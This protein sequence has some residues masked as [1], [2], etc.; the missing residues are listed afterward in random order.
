MNKAKVWFRAFRPFAYSASITPVAVG[1]ALAADVV[2]LDWPLAVLTVLG[3]VLLHTGTNLVN[4]AYDH[5]KGVD[6][7]GAFGGS[8]VI[9]EGLLS[10]D[11]VRRGGLICFGL[12]ALIGLYLV[13]RVGWGIA[14]FGAA[15]LLLGYLYTGGKGAYKYVALGELG[16]FTAMGILMVLGGYYVQT[17]RLDIL[18]LLYSVPIGFLV[19]AIL[20][21]NNFRDI[22]HDREVGIRTIPILLGRRACKVSYTALVV[23]SYVWIAGM[24]VAGAA[25]WTTL[26]VVLAAPTAVPVVKLILAAPDDRADAALAPVDMLSAKHHMAFGVMLLAGVIAARFVA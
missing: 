20:H 8:G 18:P 19:V 9:Q 2:R 5:L 21:A 24:V 12:A 10:V 4:D 17:R 26:A 1:I 16:V 13:F 23:G 22:E 6:G 25:P 15:G 11:A 3:G 7:A 14:A